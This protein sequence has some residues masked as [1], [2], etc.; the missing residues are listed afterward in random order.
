VDDV[1]EEVIS[2]SSEV[3]EGSDPEDQVNVNS[4]MKNFKIDEEPN[5]VPFKRCSVGDSKE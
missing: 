3:C 5:V 2:E 1:V 4:L